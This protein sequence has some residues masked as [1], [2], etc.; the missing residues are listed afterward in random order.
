MSFSAYVIIIGCTIGSIYYYFKNLELAN[1]RDDHAKLASHIETI[2]RNLD[3]NRDKLQQVEKLNA[4]LIAKSKTSASIESRAIAENKANQ[5]KLQLQLKDLTKKYNELIE[6]KTKLETEYQE[7]QLRTVSEHNEKV[8]E[9]QLS[10]ASYEDEI[11]NK[12]E[13]TFDFKLNTAIEQVVAERD[14]QI[15]QLTDELSKVKGTLNQEITHHNESNAT[16][17]RKI[18]E[19]QHLKDETEKKYNEQAVLYDKLQLVNKLQS[20]ENEQY[21]K[22]IAAKDE[23]VES[24]Q[25]KLKEM[26]SDF[27]QVT[28]DLKESRENIVEIENAAKDLK[29]SQ[30]LLHKHLSLEKD[31]KTELVAKVEKLEK[32]ITSKQLVIDEQDKKLSLIEQP[33]LV[34]EDYLEVLKETDDS[35]PH[36]LLDHED[37]VSKSVDNNSD[38]DEEAF[39]DNVFSAKSIGVLSLAHK[40]IDILRQKTINKRQLLEQQNKDI[41]DYKQQLM[42]VNTNNVVLGCEIISNL[43][44]LQQELEAKDKDNK[45]NQKIDEIKNIVNS[46]TSPVD[47]NEVVKEE[48]NTETSQENKIIV[49]ETEDSSISKDQDTAAESSTDVISNTD[50]IDNSTTAETPLTELE[51]DTVSETLDTT[52]TNNDGDVSQLDDRKPIASSGSFDEQIDTKTEESLRELKNLNK[53]SDTFEIKNSVTQSSLANTTSDEPEKVQLEEVSKESKDENEE[54]ESEKDSKLTPSDIVIDKSEPVKTLDDLLDERK[55]VKGDK[56]QSHNEFQ[57][58][59]KHDTAIDSHNEVKE[60]V[61]DNSTVVPKV[62]EPH[63]ETEKETQSDTTHESKLTETNNEAENEETESDAT[64]EPLEETKK[65]TAIEPKVT[66]SF[67]ESKEDKTE[68]VKISNDAS[69]IE[70]KPVETEIV[71]SK[72]VEPLVDDIKDKGKTEE[73]SGSKEPKVDQKLETV[74]DHE[75]DKESK[76]DDY[77][78]QEKELLQKKE[79]FEDE[80]Q[81]KEEEAPK[82]EA[83]S[84]VDKTTEV[85]TPFKDEKP[86]KVENDKDEVKNDTVSKDDSIVKPSIIAKEDKDGVEEVKS[87]SGEDKDQGKDK[88][89]NDKDNEEEDKCDNVNQDEDNKLKNKVENNNDEDIDKDIVIVDKEKDDKEGDKDKEKDV[90]DD[91]DDKDDNKVVNAD[92]DDKE[93]DNEEDDTDNDNDNNTLKTPFDFEASPSPSPSISSQSSQSQKS[94]P[95]KKN[96][97]KG[98]K[99]NKTTF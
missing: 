73:K 71:E 47:P 22:E 58:E 27:I 35:F 33:L 79:P 46:F 40:Y 97:K 30:E 85:T 9:L 7:K 82:L 77:K 6:E 76:I 39:D 62:I 64:A 57:K 98:K 10:K 23:E 75:L 4:E 21:V 5:E 95:L 60:K 89:D 86:S 36:S 43:Q 12:L 15:Q 65:D 67:D 59:T 87:K 54:K 93:V 1:L 3:T 69:K 16:N 61:K 55:E 52:I 99:K 63:T 72:K 26:N 44:I 84:K 80:K 8:K 14:L 18:S 78:H 11:K 24:L 92:D 34:L 17:E 96:K 38:V 74:L 41:E 50:D 13:K 81:I 53:L 31:L 51:K 20:E 66:E 37:G 88:N 90:E 48:D 91:K 56:T 29:L 49:N 19:L 32:D 70:A 2:Q 42:K 45:V 68:A 83:P 25:K 28:K 94:S